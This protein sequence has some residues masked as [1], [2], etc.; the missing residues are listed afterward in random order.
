VKSPGGKLL[1]HRKRAVSRRLACGTAKRNGQGMLD[2]SALLCQQ[3]RAVSRRIA[4]ASNLQ[5]KTRNTRVSPRDPILVARKTAR[6][7]AV[8][9]GRWPMWPMWSPV[10]IGCGCHVALRTLSAKAAGFPPDCARSGR[11][12]TASHPDAGHDP[13]AAPVLATTT[14][15]PARPGAGQNERGGKTRRAFEP[16]LNYC[17]AASRRARAA[18]NR[19]SRAAACAGLSAA[20]ARARRARASTNLCAFAAADRD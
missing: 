12:T 7:P 17:A 5:R 1:C 19:A 8:A 2:G 15:A 6:F 9:D 10:R 16:R 11:A 3:I 14:P 4:F 13:P 20:H 18:A